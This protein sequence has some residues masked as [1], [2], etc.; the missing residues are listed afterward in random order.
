MKENPKILY[1][2]RLPPNEYAS[3]RLIKDVVRKYSFDLLII[4][5]DCRLDP[6]TLL[7]IIGNKEAI[8][9]PGDEDDIMITKACRSLGILCSGSIYHL[10]NFTIA[11]VSGIDAIQDIKRI[12]NILS[13][14]HQ[15]RDYILVSHYP[16]INELYLTINGKTISLN[17]G[18]N[19]LSDFINRSKVML[20]T[21]VKYNYV[22][23][24]KTCLIIGLRS[25][26]GGHSLLINI[27]KPHIINVY[28]LK[29][30]P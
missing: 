14:E 7:N 15:S 29:I 8:W 23:V 6:S 10:G 9:V 25:S 17:L 28:F 30:I 22:N 12:R 2:A 4:G 21:H 20:S 5:G 13:K 16:L 24:I 19:E 11:C 1:L 26:S 27:R 3:I 18:L